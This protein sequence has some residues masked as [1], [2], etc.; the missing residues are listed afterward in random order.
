MGGR[1][2]RRRRAARPVHPPGADP[3]ATR[4]AW[5]TAS[6]STPRAGRSPANPMMA[7]GLIRIGE[8]AAAHHPDGAPA[9]RWPTPPRA[10]ACSRTSS[11]CWR[12][13]SMSKQPRRRRRH[14][15][16]QARRHPGRRVAS[17]ASCGRRPCGPSRTPSSTWADI[18]A[19]VIGKAPD[20][21]EGVMMPELYLADA[22][23]AYGQARCC[24]CTPP[25][26]SGG[27]TAIVASTSCRPG[28]H[29]RVLTVAFEKQSESDAMWALSLPIPFAP[30]RARRRRRLLRPP[31]PG[32]HAAARAR[33]TTSGSWWR[34]RTG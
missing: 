13:R 3:R 23:G 15:P 22:L 25:A 21:F 4:S 20:F 11:A 24:G 5:A 16:D 7:A 12:G 30:A 19:V 29:E 14:R 2:G 18:D 9:G 33:R 27:S 26:A 31:H 28:I 8:A 34:S 17:P 32:L 10:R 1:P 6:T